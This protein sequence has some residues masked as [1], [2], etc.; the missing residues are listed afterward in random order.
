MGSA[1]IDASG[2]LTCGELNTITL[3]YTA[4]HFGIDDSGSIKI[5]FRSASDQTRFQMEKPQAIGYV[6][7]KTSNGAGVNT[8]YESNRN[9]RPWHHT[10]YIQCKRFLAEGDKIIVCFGDRSQGGPGYRTQTFAEKTLE[11]RVHVDAFATYDYVVLPEDKQPKIE[12][13]AGPPASFF[14]ILPTL[15]TVADQFSLGI[16][17]E[18]RWG[19]PT[20]RNPT[21]LT[22]H[23]SRPV[24]GLPPTVNMSGSGGVVRIE[25]LSVD[26]PG[27]L[28]VTVKDTHGATVAVSNTLVSVS[29]SEFRHFWSDM[30]GQSEETIGTNSA[31]DYFTFARDKALVDICGH[32]G[33]DFQVTDAFWRELNETTAAF[34]QPGRFLALPG[35]EWS[36]NTSVGGDHNVWYRQEGRPI[37]RSHRA[38]VMEDSQPESDALDASKLFERLQDEDALV[39]AHVGGR[40]AD[41]GYAHDAKL[42]PSVEVHS[43]WGTFEWI[44]EEALT[45]GYRIGIVGGSDDHKGRPGA[46]Y[47]GATKFG[48]YGGLTCHLLPELSRDA[49]FS[50]FRQRRHYATTGC[51]PYIDFRLSGL[52]GA[53]REWS[54]DIVSTNEALIGDIIQCEGS[55]AL[56][57]L[58]IAAHRGI[59]RVDIRDGLQTLEVVKPLAD[60]RRQGNR[61]R[62]QCEGAE[63]KGRGRL[64]NWDVQVTLNG[65]EVLSVNPINFWNPDRKVRQ[66]G[67]SVSWSN[68]TTGGAHAVDIWLDDASSGSLN[69]SSDVTSFEL[70]LSALTDE[71]YVVSCGGLKKAVRITRLPDEPLPSSL[72]LTRTITFDS[73]TERRL[74]ARIVFEDG[75]M[76]WTSPIYVTKIEHP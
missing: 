5:S 65:P 43:A 2:P 71:D 61:L 1:E 35:Y 31:R 56:L 63:Y 59:E 46:S 32:Q 9:I 68:A 54:S 52:E 39:V 34:E 72:E 49:L 10:L 8:W 45:A 11:F 38:L 53:T 3:T 42:E 20:D 55:S 27:E 76:A 15:R 58:R 26:S 19:N 64:V 73:T 28:A 60:K 74:F 7:V 44:F 50:A 62:V 14:A 29:K 6:S 75:H 23:S 41:V 47:P 24:K 69:F 4:G 16:K 30:H 57:S 17:A 37:Y 25:G 13:V 21:T 22:L 36:G 12:L 18:D 51:R 66:E 40:Y 33:N 70:N 67:S 48:S